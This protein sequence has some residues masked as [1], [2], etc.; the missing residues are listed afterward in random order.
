MQYG[1]PTEHLDTTVVADE[2]SAIVWLR[3]RLKKTPQPY[4]NIQPAF[5]PM[6]SH[7]KTNERELLSLDLLLQQNFLCYD[8]SGPVPEQIHAY[9]SSNWKELRN[10]SK[11][12]PTLRA[13]AA[14]PLVHT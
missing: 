8:G 12:D 3:A 4:S 6:L 5:M 14:R 7:L 10:R 2:Q 9:L 13:K 11:D 1:D